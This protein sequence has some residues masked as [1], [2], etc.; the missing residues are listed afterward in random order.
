ME[1]TKAM[2]NYRKDK[3]LCK[4]NKNVTIINYLIHRDFLKWNSIFCSNDP[5]H[6]E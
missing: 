3:K 2:I 4:K 6:F 5:L 1:D